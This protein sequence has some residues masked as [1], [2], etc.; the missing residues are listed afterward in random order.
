M[1]TATKPFEDEG[2][3][4]SVIIGEGA[5][6]CKCL[7]L[8]RSHILHVELSTL[9]IVVYFYQIKYVFILYE[10]TSALAYKKFLLPSYPQI[11]SYHGHVKTK[12]R[13]NVNL[14]GSNLVNRNIRDYEHKQNTS[15]LQANHLYQLRFLPP[16]K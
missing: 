3:I 5:G 6:I 8:S 7:D 11:F 14:F 9:K 10:K 16:V 4:F 15:D 13:Q 2:F 1:C 12:S